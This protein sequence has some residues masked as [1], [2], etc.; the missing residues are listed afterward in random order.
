MGKNIGFGIIGEDHWYWSIGCAY[1]LAVNPNTRFVAMAAGTNKELAKKIA[2]AYKADNF[3]EDYRKLLENP[4][5]DSVIITTTT[6]RQAAIAVEAAE[7]GKNILLNK[8]I[9]RTLAEADKIIK[10]SEKNK[11]KVMVIAAKSNVK[12]PA[13]K[14]IEDG[15]IG[16]PYAIHASFY[17]VPPLREPG[18]NE[19]GWFVD[20]GKVAGGGF[21]DHAVFLVGKLEDYFNST[22]SRIY[23]EIGKFK[24]KDW[25]V[26]DHGIALARFS[27][28]SMA[29]IEAT[30]T[31]TI[32]SHMRVHIIGTEGE[33]EI[34]GNKIKIS[35]LNGKYK[36]KSTEIEF[37]PPNPF[38]S[39]TYLNITV[40]MPPIVGSMF[41]DE[42]AGYILNNE[43]PVGNAKVARRH[44]ECC[45]AA[46]KSIE[47]GSPVS[48]PFSE[49][50]DVV[51]I[52]AKL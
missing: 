36:G 27:N 12:E 25:S 32:D 20:P 6:D 13:L 16:K 26:E 45:L 41:V 43:E 47:L 37:F 48:I 29:T 15:V 7:K 44:L 9:A 23:A 11:I 21:I 31:S 1:A 8:P 51:S 5:V 39:D 30:F 10:A 52:L 40:P 35:S 2:N 22:I 24:F 17:A 42:F 46:Y 18:I 19:P 34:L 50:I 3:Y 33:L 14:Y 28:G 4:E 49:D 38:F